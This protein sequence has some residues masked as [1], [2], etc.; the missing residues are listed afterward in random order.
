M[1]NSLDEINKDKA[2]ILVTGIMRSGT[3]YV[4][5]V[6]SKH[7][8]LYYIHEPFSKHTGIKGVEHW[9][10]YTNDEQSYYSNLMDKFMNMDFKYRYF[11]PQNRNFFAKQLKKV[12]GGSAAWSGL[13][14]KIYYHKSKS[15]LIKDPLSS[16]LTQRYIE[17][18]GIKTIAMVR[19]PLAFYYSNKRLGWDFDINE[20]IRQEELIHDYF[21]DELPLL[22]SDLNLPQKMAI[23]W[24]CI[25]KYFYQIGKIHS[26]TKLH[27]VRHEDLCEEPANVFQE[28][29]NFLGLEI[30][31]EIN[32]HIKNT[33]SDLNSIDAGDT[34]HLLKRNSKSL[35]EYWVGKISDEE[36]EYILPIVSEIMDLYY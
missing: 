36:R 25:Y 34:I 32:S 35:K 33:T 23:L 29:F 5:D 27:F 4:G 26:G 8:S 16:L 11:E 17:K 31:T 18:Y 9:F 28:I 15:M 13:K 24:K 3:T 6:L 12:I 22:Q 30:E 1:I 20:L 19:H 2:H 7:K 10:P 14:Y 21:L